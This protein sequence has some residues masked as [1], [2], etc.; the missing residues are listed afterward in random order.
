MTAEDAT[1][2]GFPYVIMQTGLDVFLRQN[3]YYMW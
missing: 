3:A 2:V 1:E